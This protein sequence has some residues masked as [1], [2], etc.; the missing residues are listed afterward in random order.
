MQWMSPEA[1]AYL[2]AIGKGE[3][4]AAVDGNVR[5]ACERFAVT[6]IEPL[7]GGIAGAVVG[8]VTEEGAGVVLKVAPPE[9]T[10]LQLP[11]MRAMRGSGVPE[12]LGEAPEHDA[13]LMER[14]DARPLEAGRPVAATELAALIAGWIDRPAP[15]VCVDAQSAMREWLD[16][17]SRGAALPNALRNALAWAYETVDLLPAGDRLLHG[18]LTRS[19]LLASATQLFAVDPRG[20]RGPIAMEAGLAA[21]WCP[22]NQNESVPLAAELARELR[23]DLRETL[24]WTAARAAHSGASKHNRGELADA[25]NCYRVYE[26]AR[27][28]IETL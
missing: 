23:C 9:R 18:D 19:N 26:S 7:Y 20:V 6:P 17:A 21:V 15:A 11:T 13:F 16:E 2:N 28:A 22:A 4:A 24:S 14:L 25:A 3:W 10:A 27:G 8:C 5:A 12:I 1:N